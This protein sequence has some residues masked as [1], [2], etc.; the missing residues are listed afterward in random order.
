[1]APNRQPGPICQEGRP[2][3]IE[4][5]TLM[6]RAP[7]S[8]PGSIGGPQQAAAAPVTLRSEEVRA[9]ANSVTANVAPL[10]YDAFVR[11]YVY[12]PAAQAVSEQGEELVRKGLL[13]RARAAEWVNAQ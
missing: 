5:D 8:H 10:G 1:M 7:Y 12:E 2:V 3:S 6:C 13:S 11:K 4:D 9:T